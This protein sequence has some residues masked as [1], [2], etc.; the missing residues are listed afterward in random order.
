MFTRLV[1][2]VAVIVATPVA[3]AE[4]RLVDLTHAFDE[5][6]VY[7][8]TADGFEL[9]IDF[10]GTTDGGWHYEANTIRTSEHGGTHLDAPIHFADG[11]W[12]TEEIPLDR[13]IGPGIVIDAELSSVAN[14]D[15]LVTV[16][17]F[18]RWEAR[19]GRVPEGAIV[20]LRTGF[21]RFW[22]DREAYMGTAKRGQEAVADLS[23]PGLD[24]AAARWLVDERAIHAIGIDTPSID[25]GPSKDFMAHRILFAA[26]IPAFEN[27]GD[28]SGLPPVGFEVIALPMKIRGG[29]GGPLRIVARLTR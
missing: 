6:T 10:R 7:W 9:S 11:S 12:H 3:N 24:P 21:A 20:L 28:M 17:D 13:L 27:V 29:S 8:P 2:F 19:H 1:V 23:F 26:N 4:Q 18:E 14:R 16:R 15:Y 5:S 22:P 25:H